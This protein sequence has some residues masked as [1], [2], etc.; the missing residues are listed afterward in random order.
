MSA[1]HKKKDLQELGIN[2]RFLIDTLTKYQNKNEEIV[3]SL[4]LIISE[5]EENMPNGS[6][7]Y[8]PHFEGIVS[9]LDAQR[10]IMR[11][12]QRYL[13]SG[14]INELQDLEC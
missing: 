5:Y 13:E 6:F 8:V 10:F 4:T 12:F 7:S 2:S 3:F 11:S 9:L 14:D 1:T